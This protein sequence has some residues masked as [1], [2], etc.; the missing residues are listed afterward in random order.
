MFLGQ[1]RRFLPLPDYD[2]TDPAHVILSL[3][4]R[5][6]DEKYS[7]ALLANADFTLA[8]IVALDRVQKG[9]SPDETILQ[10]LRKRHL[11]EGRRPHLHIS[12]TVA[13]ATGQ[14]AAY[15]R[16]RRQDDTFLEKLVFDYLDQWKQATRKDIDEVLDKKLPDVFTPA[17]RAAKIHNLLSRLRRRGKIRND[18]TRTE[19]RWVRVP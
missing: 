14:K 18:G 16:T 8:E 12:A 4:G 3:P 13:A 17:Q 6:I 15:I 1:A 10:S 9:C 7:R 19:P 11:I 5:F 2:L